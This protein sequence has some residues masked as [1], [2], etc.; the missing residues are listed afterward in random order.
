MSVVTISG[1]PCA[2]NGSRAEPGR[3]CGVALGGH[4]DGDDLPVVVDGPVHVPP[5]GGDLDGGLADEPAVPRSRPSALESSLPNQDSIEDRI[6]EMNAQVGPVPRALGADEQVVARQALIDAFDSFRRLD[7]TTGLLAGTE[8]AV[9]GPGHSSV[10]ADGDDWWLLHH[11]YDGA[12][13]GDPTLG[14]QPVTWDADGWPA[15]PGSAAA[16][17][18]RR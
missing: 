18:R 3:S 2:L 11:F 9:I 15:V 10:L 14:I 5:G 8:G 1:S 7:G 12:A 4:E 17:G 6:L 16:G 13:G